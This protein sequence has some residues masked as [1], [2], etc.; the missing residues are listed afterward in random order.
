ML[1]VAVA[2]SSSDDNVICYVLP[3]LWMRS[4]LPIINQAKATPMGHILK[5]TH[6]G[7]H[8]GRSLMSAIA[9]LVHA[10]ILVANTFENT[11]LNC[12]WT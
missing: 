8:W 5:V 3:V 4:C 12:Q 11:K 1:S 7:Q 6:Q 9:L 10:R 2:R